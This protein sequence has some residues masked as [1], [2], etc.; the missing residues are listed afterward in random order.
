MEQTTPPPE[1][2]S[3]AYFPLETIAD[4]QDSLLMAITDLQRLVG[5]VDHAA[6][7]LVE[8]FSSINAALCELQAN[9]QA[10]LD[11]IV[12]DLHK[13]ILELQFHDMATQLINHTSLVLQGC[14]WR[15]T[16]Q[17]MEV[18]GNEQPMAEDPMP[19]RPSPV[20]QSEMDSGSVD[21]FDG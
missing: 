19:E 18:E 6:L 2:Q 9:D 3:I 8:R 20:S 5:L 7:N 11:R 21:L 14:A 17:G 10:G 12:N 1:H 13:A 4:V 16:N 15:L